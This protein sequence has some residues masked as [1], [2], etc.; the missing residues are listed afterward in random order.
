MTGLGALTLLGIFVV[1]MMTGTPIAVALGLAGTAAIWVYDLGIMSVPTGFYTGIAKYPL[2]AIPV[3][4]LAGV[5]F[6]RAGW[7]PASSIWRARWSGRGA[8]AWAS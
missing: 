5:I 1:L 2:L 7:R 4:I 6:E 3:F 8:A